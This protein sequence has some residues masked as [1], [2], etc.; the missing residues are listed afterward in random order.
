MEAAIVPIGCLL[1]VICTLTDAESISW[2]YS[3]EPSLD[4]KVS[5]VSLMAEHH[6]K[7]LPNCAVKCGEDCACFGFNPLRRK[8]RIHESCDPSNMTTNEPEWSYFCPEGMS[9]AAQFYNVSLMLSTL[10]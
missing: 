10:Y 6:S 1:L 4:N 8:C 5:N 7:S 2:Y 3:T 9:S